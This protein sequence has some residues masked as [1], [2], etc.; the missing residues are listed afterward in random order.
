[1]FL[2]SIS[3]VVSLVENSTWNSEVFLVAGSNRGGGEGGTFYHIEAIYRVQKTSAM[4]VYF[5]INLSLE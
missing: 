2:F 4:I 5:L 3:G 1:M